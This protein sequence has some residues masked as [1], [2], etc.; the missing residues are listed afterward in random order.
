MLPSSKHPLVRQHS[1]SSRG[2][3]P[4][5]QGQVTCQGVLSRQESGSSRGLPDPSASLDAI[6]PGPP[7]RS[8]P[9]ASD[10][11]HGV[12]SGSVSPI[13]PPSNQVSPPPSYHDIPGTVPAHQGVSRG[14]PPSYEE[15]VDPNAEPPSYD[16]LFGRIRDTHKASRNVVDFVVKVI[17][18]LLGTIGCTIACSITVVIPFC[19][20]VI[21]SVYFHDCPAEPYIPIF[22]IVGGSFSAFKYF[23]GVLSRV[24]RAETGS[25]QD[26][27]PTHPVQSLITFFLCGWFIT[28][29]VWVYRIYWPDTQLAGT[30][31]YCNPV[32]YLFAFWLI[33]TAYIFLGLFTSCIC[34]FSIVS[35]LLKREY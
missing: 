32:V 25:E 15:A 31:H 24:R 6:H 10:I 33:T 16:S 17:L 3:G 34:C 13:E 18:L 9:Y 12:T 5:G 28:G 7:D 21:G 8:S 30:E 14:P 23:I 27:Q 22:L 29:C 19:M 26:P 11:E 2:Q 35:V 4:G 20:I 1:D